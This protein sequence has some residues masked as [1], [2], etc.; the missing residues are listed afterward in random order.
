M[1]IYCVLDLSEPLV[2]GGKEES[3]NR[4]NLYFGRNHQFFCSQ[5]SFC[6]F[7]TKNTIKRSDDQIVYS[8]I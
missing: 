1:M 7:V 2:F 5:I 8:D 6:L 3:A 4:Q